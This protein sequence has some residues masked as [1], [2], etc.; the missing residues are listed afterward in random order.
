MK[1][2]PE[3][4]VREAVEMDNMSEYDKVC[5]AAEVVKEKIWPY[6]VRAVKK[7]VGVIL[8][9]GLGVFADSLVD[10]STVDY[11]QIPGFAQSRVK[12]HAGQLV[13]GTCGGTV[14]LAMKGRVHLYEGY[15][16]SQVVLPA[17]TLIKAGCEELIITCAAG[18]INTALEPGDLVIINDHL[19]FTCQNPLV[20][21]N[22]DRLGPRFP[23]MS[24]AYDLKLRELAFAKARELKIPLREG[25]YNWMLGPSYE[26]P[27]EIRLL[28]RAGADLAGM[29]TVP[30][31][32]AARHMGARV[33]GISC[34][35]NKAAGLQAELS[36][37][38]VKETA[39]RVSATF[40]RLLT[41]IVQALGKE[42]SSE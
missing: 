6:S 5:K 3:Q 8:G 9:S 25:V 36:H 40:I 7:K 2:T 33:L 30:E 39:N 23:D 15:P 38:E 22:D 31:V 32:I 24:V 26:T 11:D 20:G 12:G 29:S 17:R 14:V 41:G 42:G 13:A 16:L 37:D 4:E 19:N 21:D 18:G 35:T 10:P 28:R 27:A 1:Q 34:V